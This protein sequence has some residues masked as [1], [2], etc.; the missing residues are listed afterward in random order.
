VRGGVLFALCAYLLWGLLPIYWKLLAAVP[1]RE[2]IGHRV[3]WAALFM[4][5][6]LAVRRRG[7]WLRGAFS[8]PRILLTSVASAT[9]LAINWLTYVWA[10]NRGFIVETSLGYFIL[11]LLT[12]L[13]GVI[14]LRERPRPW[15][16]AA[17]GTAACGILFLTFEYGGFPWIALTL[18]VTFGFYGLL[19]KTACL[20]SLEGLALETA[21]L[22]PF[23]LAYLL[24]LEQAGTGSFGHASPTVT[25]LLALTG[26]TTILPLLFYVSA[27]RRITFTNLGV[28]H[29]IAPTLQLL[30]GL[31]VYGEPFTRTRAI[32]FV[33]IWVALAIYTADAVA[34]G[35]GRFDP[36]A[37]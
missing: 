20:S 19:R 23:A 34:A 4:A 14:F 28:L 25:L 24:R 27:A 26:V 10:V 2:I 29:Y 30:I 7:G 12:V 32:G 6:I 13:L 3:V 37:P 17:I 36:G 9:L 18:A 22:T 16:W 11:P 1:A 21:F 35:R 15:Q 8:S 33:I 31:L 5:A